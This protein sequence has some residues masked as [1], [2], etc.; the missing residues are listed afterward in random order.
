MRVVV[1]ALV[2]DLAGLARIQW[3]GDLAATSF[4]VERLQDINREERAL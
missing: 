4:V 2:M 3:R 1:S